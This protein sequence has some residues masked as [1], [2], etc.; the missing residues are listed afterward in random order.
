MNTL[1]ITQP[2]SLITLEVALGVPSGDLGTMATQN[3]DDVDITG[4][5]ALL[6]F[7]ALSTTAGHT[8]TQGQM[9]WNA[10]EETVDLGVNG[11]AF[12]LG[13]ET[14]YHVRN[15]T[16]SNI[17]KGTPVM[18]TGTVG[19]SGKITVGPMNGTSIDNAKFFLGIAGENILA[20]EDGKVKD[21]GKIRN[22]NTNAFNEG[23]VLWVS[24][25]NPAV[26]TAAQ[27]TGLKLAVAF[28]ITKGN[29]GTLFIRATQGSKLKEL[30]DV[31]IVNP[32]NGDIL[33]YQ[34]GVWTN[35]QP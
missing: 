3:A 14:D 29:N 32:Q 23:E 33:V 12:A 4:G 25:Q 22:V 20:G 6:D 5:Q 24:N 17:T 30:H 10:D 31:N 8:V 18:A 27:P 21:F 19:G 11:I 1:E 9:A 2:D 28:V 13:Q 7:L 15:S 16:G 26:L 35:Q 34:S